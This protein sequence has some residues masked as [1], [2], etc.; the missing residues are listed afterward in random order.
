MVRLPQCGFRA[1]L[2]LVLVAYLHR[3]GQTN[4]PL[5]LPQVILQDVCV[6]FRLPALAEIPVR[7]SKMLNNFLLN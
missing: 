4:L 5:R 7:L 1:A 6:I 2:F 3:P